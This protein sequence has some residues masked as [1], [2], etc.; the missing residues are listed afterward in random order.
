[1]WYRIGCGLTEI[2]HQK[3]SE[4]Y[5]T[6]DNNIQAEILDNYN[7][8]FSSFPDEIRKMQNS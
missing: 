5:D 4:K 6:Y 8:R 2:Y 1:M 7:L 3:L